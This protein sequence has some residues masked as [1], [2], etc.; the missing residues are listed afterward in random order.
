MITATQ[1][2]FERLAPTGPDYATLPIREAFDWSAA[3]R[4]HR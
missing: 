4:P 2:D 1:P 3:V